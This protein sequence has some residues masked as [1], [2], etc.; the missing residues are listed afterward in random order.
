[1]NAKEAKRVFSWKTC[2]EISSE[3]YDKLGIPEKE[4]LSV[5]DHGAL[6]YMPAVAR[7]LK[8]WMKEK[9]QHKV[10]ALSS[11]NSPFGWLANVHEIFNATLM[12][13]G[14]LIKYYNI[15]R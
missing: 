9:A 14:L 8:R 4:Q 7:F 5:A 15:N 11:K 12:S 10:D 13:T 2:T 1:M 6:G 3:I